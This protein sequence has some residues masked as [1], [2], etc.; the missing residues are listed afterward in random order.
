MRQKHL[1]W[2]ID[3]EGRQP[4]DHSAMFPVEH[5]RSAPSSGLPLHNVQ[6]PVES[7]RSRTHGIHRVVHNGGQRQNQR[8]AWGN[9]PAA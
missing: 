8:L 9:D 4:T 5:L 2:S 1:F 3:R 7:A 6:N